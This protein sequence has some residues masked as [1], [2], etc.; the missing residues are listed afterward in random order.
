M[1]ATRCSRTTHRVWVIAV[2]LASPPGLRPYTT[3]ALADCRSC[4]LAAAAV[5]PQGGSFGPYRIEEL[6]PPNRSQHAAVFDSR[7]SRMVVF[8]G[9]VASRGFRN[10]VWMLDVRGRVEWE[11]ASPFGDPPSPR[12]G[13]V[14]LYDSL[15]DRMLVFGGEDS[16]GD[17][18]DL[19]ELRLQGRPRWRQLAPTGMAPTPRKLAVAMIA[20]GSSRAFI[21][22]GDVARSET[23][24]YALTVAGVPTWRRVHSTGTGPPARWGIAACYVPTL[25]GFVLMGGSS[26]PEP[27]YFDGSVDLWLLAVDS[28]AT[29]S[30]LGPRYPGAGP[31]GRVGAQLAYDAALGAVILVGGEGW[32]CYSDRGI[33]WALQLSD[34]HWAAVEPSQ[35]RPYSRNYAAAVL[36]PVQ[37]RLLLHGGSFSPDGSE[38][39]GDTWAL[40]LDA[41][42]LWSR[43]DPREPGFSASRWDGQTAAYDPIRNRVLLC[44]GDAVWS[45]ALGPHSRWSRLDVA[46]E[47][48]PGRKGHVV[49]Y[50]PEHD[51]LLLFGGTT[52]PGS[53]VYFSDLW[54]LSLG[55]RAEWSRLLP[56]G[57]TPRSE[58]G[59]A[60]DDPLRHRV[61]LLGSSFPLE[62]RNMAVWELSLDGPLAWTRVSTTGQ[63]PH[64]RMA[65]GAIYDP[66]RDRLVL[67]GGG[68]PG[69]DSWNV[70]PYASWL[71]LSDDP[72]WH[73]MI[74][75]PYPEPRALLATAYDARDDAMVI[76]GGFV[77][78][79]FS[80]GPYRDM[81]AL[82]LAAFAWT[83]FVPAGGA[84]PVWGA[85]LGVHDGR[86]DRLILL[87]N[88]NVWALDLG[89]GRTTRSAVER[90]ERGMPQASV[91]TGMLH[92]ESPVSRGRPFTCE[93]QTRDAT[94]AR[95]ELLDL[96][97]RRLWR[98][99][100][101][102]WSAGVHTVT[103]DGT[104]S[105]PPG[106][107]FLRLTWGS[108]P[109]T[110]R[111]LK[112]P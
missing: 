56:D 9:S 32:S 73:R 37:G 81:W 72:D 25:S 106:V 38:G 108:V 15:G 79:A 28:L 85:P 99:D 23:T 87:E 92:A 20:P 71:P 111:L 52:F 70:S 58:L 42:P 83:S 48:P 97:G 101:G 66:V 11:H 47:Q 2:V 12:A 14:A 74:T 36:D 107:Y 67:E 18:N 86:C 55:S 76:A 84:S 7:R 5:S 93:V 50:D 3:P 112:L 49:V 27:E 44:T 13:A 8:G 51:R 88:D 102:T 19:W 89:G 75:N 6:P 61:L 60:L 91:D 29:W 63:D 54:A 68:G 104:G 39:R 98:D 40:A 62:S 100:P 69:G 90:I 103:L 21:F 17:R 82:D 105:L 30:R 16:T 94:P 10:D 41:A 64:A 59:T 4:S 80:R 46:G 33:V 45:Y 57:Q 22:G 31:C 43:I 65:A 96:A 1:P 78:G 77:P 26:P 95:L 109:T 34:L 110:V 53:G 35:D 24:L